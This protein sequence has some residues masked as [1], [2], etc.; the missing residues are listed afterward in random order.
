MR[1]ARVELEVL[2]VPLTRPYAIA[3]RATEAVQIARVR[4]V[5][6]SGLAGH[7]SAS[8]AAEITGETIESCVAALACAEAL[9]G[10]NVGRNVGRDVGRDVGPD[11]GPDVGRDV[12]RDGGRDVG[13]D[14]GRD[15]G[16]DVGRDALDLPPLLDEVARATPRAPAARAALDMALHDLWARLR[17]RPL[18]ELLGREHR[19]L[20]TSITIGIKTLPDT[21]AEAEEYVGRGFRTLK[22]KIGESFEADVERLVRLREQVGTAVAIRAD[23]NVGYPPSTIERFFAAAE[24][25]QVEFLEQPAPR[26]HDVEIRRLP[27]AIRR[28]LAADESLHDEKD[29]LELARA[30]Q[31]YGIWNIKLMKCGGI[32]P[33]LRIARIARANGIDLMWGCMDES[34]I[35]IA[36]ALHAAYAC[37]ATRT[38]D[39]DGSFDLAR[40]PAR[41]GFALAGG[42]LETLDEPGL[43]V[44]LAP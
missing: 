4:V 33:A 35:G 40:D 24:R 23:A 2:D 39:L 30:P 6:E 36:A 32:A 38:L 5:G 29:A 27:E 22:V 25:A 17:G 37:A 8:P 13:R 14:V 1:I 26:E 11:V 21:L 31:P 28:R 7:G 34:V 20:E 18:V 43:G 16:R 19:S 9:V 3:F 10:R 44:E 12:G 15:G 42:R 41:G